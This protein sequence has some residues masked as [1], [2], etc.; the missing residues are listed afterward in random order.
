GVPV[1]DPATDTLYTGTGQGVAV[2][3]AATCNAENISGCDQ[4]PAATVSIA[5]APGPG[6]LDAATHTLYVG[7]GNDGPVSL[8]DTASCN[9]TDT[10]GCG[11]APVQT[12]T[13]GD[14]IAIDHANHAIYVSDFNDQLFEAFDGATCNATD[15]SGCGQT[16]AS[17]SLPASPT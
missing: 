17:L 11:Q 16:P 15:T 2:F 6:A 1:L 5:G 13:N 8:I 10:S 3:D 9:A 14:S 7:D 12:A 4:T